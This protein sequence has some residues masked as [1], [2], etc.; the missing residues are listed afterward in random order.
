MGLDSTMQ[1]HV[2][3]LSIVHVGHRQI[4]IRSMQKRVL[5]DG[6]GPGRGLVYRCIVFCPDL[7]NTEKTKSTQVPF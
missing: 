1:I 6:C 7:N 2:I 4:N 3:E 5:A